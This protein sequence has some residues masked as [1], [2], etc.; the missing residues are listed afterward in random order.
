MKYG[1]I[2]SKHNNIIENASNAD[3]AVDNIRGLISDIESYEQFKEFLESD[4]MDSLKIIENALYDIKSDAEKCLYDGQQMED[5]LVRK[6]TTINSLCDE[7]DSLEKSV[8]DLEDQV[9]DLQSTVTDLQ[10]QVDMFEA[11]HYDRQ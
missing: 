9:S 11:E 1:T 4:I 10:S 6:Q 3:N 5:G 7:R 2:C 8:S